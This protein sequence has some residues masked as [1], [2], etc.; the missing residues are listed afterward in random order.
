MSLS[1]KIFI[2]LFLGI[3]TGLF[4]GETAGILKPLGDVFVQLLKMAV[5]PY[6]LV[7]LIAGLGKLNYSEAKTLF[8]RVGGI[9]LLIWI[10]TFAL[11]LVLPLTFP[12]WQTASFFSTT[13]LQ[14]PEPFDF[15]QFIP[16]NPFYSMANSIVPAV[17][18]FSIA[19]GVAL[20]GIERKQTLIENL[21]IL[22]DALTR[23]MRF[24]MRLTP[25]GV[26]AIAASAAGTMPFN[27][28]GQLQVYMLTY[29][30]AAL[31][32]TFCIL[33]ALVT[34]LTPVSFWRVVSGIKEAMVT[35]FA[36]DNLLV[37]LPILADQGKRLVRDSRL[38]SKDTES[39]MD[40]IV[41]ASFNFPHAGKLLQLSF[42]LFAA[43]FTDTTTS[44][45]GYVGLMFSGLF[46]FFGKPVAAMPFLLELL[47]IPADMFEIYLAS[48][49]L[50]ARFG[51]LVSVMQT[52]VLAVLG[53]FAM[54]GALRFRFRSFLWAA[55]ITAPVLV[56]FLGGARLYYGYALEN[57]YEKDK[58]IRRMQSME[59][60]VATEVLTTS[61]PPP[62][63]DLSR[64]AL[65]RIRKRGYLRVGYLGAGDL[66]PFDYFND[67]GKLVGFD[68]VMAQSLA[69]ELGVELQLV[70]VT[71]ETMAEALNTGVCDIIMS[72]VVVTPERAEAMAF[73]TPYLDLTLAFVVR[74]HRRDEFESPGLK[75]AR[76]AV[77]NI[78]YYIEF[79]RKRI[80]DS[81]LIIVDKARDFFEDRDGK[82]DALALAAEV[83]AAWSLLYPQYSVAIPRREVIKIPIA[84]PVGLRERQWLAFVEA[85]I[86]LKKNDGSIQKLYEHWILGRNAVPA[87]P[88]WSVIRNVLGWVN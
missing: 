86:S 63:E 9:L 17:V 21:E 30:G 66:I 7:A 72:S 58:I 6:I 10:I 41:P 42:V 35:A 45:L 39:A 5:L 46:S 76:I 4:F 64:P 74:D 49:I 29:V 44:V 52:F 50:I 48:G 26:F 40:V 70:P 11:L 62:E 47:R 88:R 14:E 24:V 31:L 73:S 1:T 15:L 65:E 16:A 23:V 61:V 12:R 22:G 55:L 19:V 68:V 13:L 57:A 77:I 27:E 59:D 84:Y 38:E 33:P 34:M 81:E 71:R 32:M 36:T 83:G 54:A 82:F 20:M 56:A 80:P 43:W 79:I 78:P 85:W 28:L 75:T 67:Q 53:A 60:K 69:S 87:K 51:T 37:V 2:G 18:L 8:L 3:A 25:L